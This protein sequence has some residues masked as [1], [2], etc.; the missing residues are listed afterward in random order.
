MSKG[1]KRKINKWYYIKLKSVYTAKKVISKTKRQPTE[2]EKVPI[3]YISD[4]EII[5]RIYKEF[6][7]LNTQKNQTIQFKMGRGPK[8][9]VLQR[10]HRDSQPS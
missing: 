5:C 10:G 4:K 3:N 9:T 8:Q 2:W 7:K 1:N 6:L